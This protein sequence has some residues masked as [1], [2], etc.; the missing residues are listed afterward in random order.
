MPRRHQRVGFEAP[1]SGRLV[2][3][4]R[5]EEDSHQR[6]EQL[7]LFDGLGEIGREEI[8]F[9]T[10]FA[11]TDGTEQ[12][13]RETRATV[14]ANAFG[15]FQS[16]HLGHVHIEDGNVEGLTV[17]QPLQGRGRGGSVTRQHAPFGGLHVEDVTIGGVVIH[18]QHAFV[19]QFGLY[20]HIGWLACARQVGNFSFDGE[21]EGGAF[22]RTFAGSPHGAA[23]HFS[24]AFADRQPQ[25]SA[26]ILARG[27]RVRLG[28][29]LEDAA[30]AFFGQPDTSISHG[31]REQ[32][33]VFR[34]AVL[35]ALA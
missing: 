30:H 22:A 3:R 23:H 19:L 17:F 13:Q 16:V 5:A 10:R 8:G 15:E 9:V 25:T 21:G 29:G 20:T 4:G 7:R 35:I 6:V 28:E 26:A 31:K 14:A 27:G 34:V 1:G 11:P 18:D 32:H 2:N 24:E 33:F 12:H